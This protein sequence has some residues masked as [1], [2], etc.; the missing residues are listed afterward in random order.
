[1]QI[2][3]ELTPHSYNFPWLLGLVALFVLYASIVEYRGRR[4]L[5]AF[6]AGLISIGLLIFVLSKPF[7]AYSRFIKY[8][9]GTLNV[10]KVGGVVSALDTRGNNEI[11]IFANGERFE[12]LVVSASQCYAEP[13][14]RS[15]INKNVVIT[16]VAPPEYRSNRYAD[17]IVKIEI[18]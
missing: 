6:F 16:F 10:E 8:E 13:F 7:L 15:V 2:L 1:M 14:D 9:D 18:K 12:H 11:I 17:C 4:Y 3:F 5:P